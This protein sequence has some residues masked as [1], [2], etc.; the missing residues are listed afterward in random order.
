MTFNTRIEI[1]N[2][3]KDTY[4]LQYKT[5]DNYSYN[6]IQRANHNAK[7]KYIKW[8]P[9]AVVHYIKALLTKYNNT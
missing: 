8:N 3:T 7:P 5:V 4:L 9:V 6:T 1:Q 2:T